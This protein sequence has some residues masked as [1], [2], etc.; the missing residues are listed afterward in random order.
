MGKELQF[1]GDLGLC[2]KFKR[3]NVGYLSPIFWRQNWGSDMN[4][5]GNIWGHPLDLL[6]WNS[7]SLRFI[8]PLSQYGICFLASTPSTFIYA[9]RDIKNSVT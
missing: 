1:G 8:R 3:Q 7:P 4:F 6:I 2:L 9:I 5:S